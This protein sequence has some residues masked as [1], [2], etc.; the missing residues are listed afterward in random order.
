MIGL[1]QLE[2]EGEIESTTGK[3][4]VGVSLMQDMAAVPMIVVIPTLGR[5]D[6]LSSIG[7]AALKGLA[8]VGVCG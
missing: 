8:L 6:P 1:R 4:A 5:D 7:W 2:E 3:T